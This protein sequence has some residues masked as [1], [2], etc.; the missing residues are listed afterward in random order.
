MAHTEANHAVIILDAL[1][2]LPMLWSAVTGPF[3]PVP[4][5]VSIERKDFKRIREAKRYV[6]AKKHDGLRKLVLAGR[7]MEGQKENYL[8]SI[9]RARHVDVLWVGPH[10]DEACFNGTLLDAEYMPHGTFV[11]FDAMAVEG[12]DVSKHNFDVRC[13][14]IRRTVTSLARYIKIEDKYWVPLEHLATLRNAMNSAADGL[15]FMPICE[16][17]RRNR[18]P[19]LLKFKT[20]HTLDFIWHQKNFCYGFCRD[21]EYVFEPVKNNLGLTIERDEDCRLADGVVYE[22]E[23]IT[24]KPLTFRIVQART[25]K[26]KPNFISTVQKTLLNID[27]A[28]SFD[29]LIAA[30]AQE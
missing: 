1:H 16:P 24:N 30:F 11:C 27:E 10:S 20:H 8:V 4:T 12:F 18:H 25:D 6:V 5:P 2:L 19:N 29:D 22:C 21:R 9:D 23:P 17:I 3:I 15:I 28:I 14:R 26:T 7:L 13:E